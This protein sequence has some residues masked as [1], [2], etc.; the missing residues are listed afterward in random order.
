MDPSPSSTACPATPYEGSSQAQVNVVFRSLEGSSALSFE[1]YHP[2]LNS[3]DAPTD[4]ESSL[5][6]SILVNADKRLQLLDHELSKLEENLQQM[7]AERAAL[8]TFR[9]RTRTILSPLRRMPTELLREIFSWALPSI[10]DMAKS[11]R[12]DTGLS[13]W[14]STYI[15][16]RWRAISLSTPSLWSLFITDYDINDPT[17]PY[18]SPSL[19]ETQL[20]RARSMKVHFYPNQTVDPKPQVEI[21]QL[22]A[23]HSDRWEDLSIGLTSLIVPLLPSLRA[24]LPSLRRL[25]V[26]WLRPSSSLSVQSINCFHI[27]PS[28]VD[29]G[30]TDVSLFR[31]VLFPAHQL[32]RY[33]LNGPW[34]HHWEI[35]RQIPALVE[36]RII[37]GADEIWPEIDGIINLLHLRRL[38]ICAVTALS[39]LRAPLLEELT[40]FEDEDPVSVFRSFL[41]RSSCSIKR[42]CVEDYRALPTLQLLNCSSSITELVIVNHR[43]PAEEVQA[44]MEALTVFNVPRDKVIAPHLSLVYVGWEGAEDDDSELDYEALL[45]MV[46][47]RWKS[48]SCS[49][50]KIGLVIPDGPR[51]DSVILDT[52]NRLREDGLD[53]MLLEGM[54]ASFEIRIWDCEETWN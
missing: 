1:T 33:D 17:P 25:W 46:Q 48:E 18:Y 51:P 34:E 52:L 27:A 21:F 38:S 13:P 41:D 29:F 40:L 2:L 30:A 37:T 6:R 10:S 7:K 53:V 35:L 4:S 8:L 11:G 20:Q 12:V 45:Q 32:T 47:S 19:I 22:L 49:L 5:I 24:R 15:S 50:E 39:Y 44:L 42:L 36:A 28:L 16:S 3:N 9:A 54:A 14:V 23:R 31:P 43:E 26:Q